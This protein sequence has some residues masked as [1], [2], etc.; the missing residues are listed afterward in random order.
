MKPE[1]LDTTGF[2]HMNFAFAFF[3]PTTFQV[4]PM[5][6][7]AGTLLKSFTNL[8]EQNRRLQTWIS[9]GGW[10][11]NDPGNNPEYY[12]YLQ[13]FD[14]KGMQ[15]YVDWFNIMSYDIHGVWDSSNRFTG[16]Y[17]RPHT[18]LTE[19]DDGLSLLWRAGVSAS[20]VV[21]GLGFYG[22]SFKLTSPSCTKPGCTFS[23]GA[24]AGACT[25]ASGIL[26]LAEIGRTIDKYSLT[27]SY[28]AKAAVKWI[29]F[30][31]DQWVSYDD[32]GTFK[33][34]MDYARDLGLSGTMVWAVDQASTG[35]TSSGGI[36]SNDFYIGAAFYQKSTGISK[37]AIATYQSQADAQDSCYT[38]FCGKECAPGYSPEPYVTKGQVGDLGAGSACSDGEVQQICCK[39]GTITGE[40]AWYGFRGQGLSC[41]G[42][43]C[44]QGDTLVA[45]N[46]NH[47]FKQPE[48]GSQIYCCRGFMP[49]MQLG[50]DADLLQVEDVESS[51][52]T[53]LAKRDFRTC[54][55]QGIL[56]AGT[57]VVA[58]SVIPV[59][60][61]F[62]GAAVSSIVT[63]AC[64]ISTNEATAKKL[65]GYSPPLT[66]AQA[67]G[68][69]V[70]IG[71]SG[72]PPQQPPKGG[73]KKPTN[74]G[75]KVYGSYPLAV[76]PSGQTDC[77]LTYTCGYGKG[78]DQ[79][80]D[81][82]KYGLDKIT[83]P[84]RVFYYDERGTGTGRSK[85]RWAPA[86]NAAYRSSFGR[87]G[88]GRN[89]CEVDEFP[90]NSLQESA[91]F[92]Q[93]ALRALDGD[94]N[95]RQGA[96]FNN[97][98]SASWAPCS[99]LKKS[100]PPITWKIGNPPNANDP[101]ATAVAA[102]TIAKYG[103]DSVSGLAQCWPT[104][105]IGSGPQTTVKDH[106]FRVGVDDPLF[107]GN[108][109]AQNYRTVPAASAHPTDVNSVA[110]VKK[111]WG[112]EQWAFGEMEIATKTAEATL[113]TGYQGTSPTKVA[114]DD[115]RH[116]S[117]AEENGHSDTSAQMDKS[118]T[119]P[120]RA[121]IT[122]AP[123]RG[124]AAHLMNHAKRHGH[125]NHGHG[126]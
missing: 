114:S 81:N 64:F 57:L 28:D 82:Q 80:C 4:T 34:K 42:G 18:N 125:H 50:R 69:A 83:S 110:Y 122:P 107:G 47:Y 15:N 85:Q 3:H 5:D 112:M 8:K 101:R 104:Y 30:N 120:A 27:P 67:A 63:V 70:G 118:D 98:L 117:P 79:V 7:N 20:N 45:V 48:G 55:F 95:G 53:T 32:D 111:R 6:A 94:E 24:T 62:A 43:Q 88:T 115:E 100:N 84:I 93:Q 33:Q 71:V 49:S 60:N 126:S 35:S 109:P 116:L 77:Q 78:F 90:M 12:W 14:V 105:S 41:Y 10:S 39:T 40:C 72:L 26:S 21:M 52:P 9:V 51:D 75:P 1:D 17:V 123:T 59:I 19:I 87:S 58:A 89:R 73:P 103:F 96:D 121:T 11:F 68:V 108:W 102:K 16:P 65:V 29:T 38:S 36:S 54:A 66:R 37:A 56:S 22:R 76:Y 119:D 23:S 31:S 97:F 106:G 46:S 13:H 99:A 86:R 25:G 113:L 61:L 44:P 2:T 74:G 124:G 92:A 91:N